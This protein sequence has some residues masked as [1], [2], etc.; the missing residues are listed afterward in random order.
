MLEALYHARY[1]L[2]QDAFTSE[3]D[4]SGVLKGDVILRDRV[5]GGEFVLAHATLEAGARFRDGFAQISLGEPGQI[6]SERLFDLTTHEVIELPPGRVFFRRH[7]DGRLLLASHRVLSGTWSLFDPVSG[8]EVQISDEPGIGAPGPDAIYF[9]NRPEFL[10]PR[11]EGSVMRYSFEGERR[12]LARRASGIAQ[13]VD[14][15]VVTLLDLDE[16]LRGR[17]VLVDPDTLDERPIDDDVQSLVLLPDQTLV[18]SVVDGARS[19]V[20]VARLAPAE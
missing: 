3:D 14:E 7:E 13:L 11:S 19:G 18:Y 5:E 1:L 6:E 16:A 17:L 8:T 12:Q 4:G 10:D 9:W 15:R 20:W 2:W